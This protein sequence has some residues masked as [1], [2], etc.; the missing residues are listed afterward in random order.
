MIVITLNDCP[1]F[2]R[3]D[4][5]KWLQ[6]INTG[7]FVGKASARVRD[8]LWDRVCD[9]VQSGRATMVF[10][11]RCEQ[12]MDFRV[13]NAAWE[14]LDFDGLKLM[15]RPSPAR[16]KKLGSLRLGYSN[17]AKRR[18]AKAVSA[19]KGK[20]E[21]DYTSGKYVVVD[22]ETTGLYAKEHEIIEMGAIK[23]DSGRTIER[24]HALVKPASSIPPPIQKLTGL[25][26]EILEQDGME[27]KDALSDFIG[28]AGDLPLVAHN[29]KFDLSFL[30]AA[31]ETCGMPLLRNPSV[32]TLKLAKRNISDAANYKLATLLSHLDIPQGEQHRSNDDCEATKELYERLLAMNSE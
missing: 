2:L 11:A 1:A 23:V 16:T 18:T 6:E 9:N 13:H 8:E 32:D 21:A 3:G 24:F 29:V 14:P 15:R 26:D 5:T 19:K 22:V 31:C 12:G 25:S 28:F 7:V 27:L 20:T 10:S 17:A 4:L 30:L